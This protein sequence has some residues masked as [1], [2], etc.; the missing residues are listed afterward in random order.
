MHPRLAQTIIR[1]TS[2][3]GVPMFLA[4]MLGGIFNFANLSIENLPRYVLPS[5]YL[6]VK[7]SLLD[8]VALF[9]LALTTTNTDF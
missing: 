8:C 5:S 4:K 9:E 1:H 6:T 7:I 3:P 2:I